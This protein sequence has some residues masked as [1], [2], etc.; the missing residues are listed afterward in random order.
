MTMKD[1]TGHFAGMT[2]GVAA[3]MKDESTAQYIHECL[4]RF[5]AGDFGE[6]LEEDIAANLAELSEGVGRVLARYP[7]EY[8][9]MDDV[10][11]SATFDRD[12]PNADKDR[13][14]TVVMLCCEY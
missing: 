2:Q 14:A 6:I 13:N 7:Q 11:I 4:R 10:Y 9:L 12:A 1:I 8:A 5:Y 3:A